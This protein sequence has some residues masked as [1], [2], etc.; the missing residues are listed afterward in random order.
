MDLKVVLEVVV[1]IVVEVDNMGVDN[2]VD[3]IE[4]DFY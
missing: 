4:L 2:I 1:E 3:W